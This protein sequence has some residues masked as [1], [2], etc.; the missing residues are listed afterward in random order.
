MKNLLLILILAIA[1]SGCAVVQS[2]TQLPPNPAI[3]FGKKCSVDEEGNV[4]YSSIWIYNK[5]S[6]LQ[7]SKEACKILKK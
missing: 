7:A 4:V 2:V 3:S 6:G 5:E 1:T